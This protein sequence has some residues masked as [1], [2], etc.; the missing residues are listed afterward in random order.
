MIVKFIVFGKPQGKARPRFTK[1]GRVY[2]PRKTADYEKQIRNA[3]IQASDGFSFEELAVKT[4]IVAF[5][6][7]PK[8]NFSDYPATKPDVDNISKIVLDALNGVAYRDDKQVV[9]CEIEKCYAYDAEPPRIEVAVW[10]A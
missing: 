4:K 9:K 7:K 10:E 3:Y 8:R 6:Q 5:M 2:T 1:N